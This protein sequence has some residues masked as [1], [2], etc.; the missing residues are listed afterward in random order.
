MAQSASCMQAL[1]LKSR[2][3]LD[4]GEGTML[5]CLF[6]GKKKKV[7]IFRSFS[8]QVVVRPSVLC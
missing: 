3:G 8:S 2:D 5:Q 4:R 6:G 7:F 1:H